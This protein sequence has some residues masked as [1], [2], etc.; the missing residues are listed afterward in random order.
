MFQPED[1]IEKLTRL[2]S[3]SILMLHLNAVVK[4]APKERALLTVEGHAL[5]LAYPTTGNTLL[6][7]RQSV[8]VAPKTAID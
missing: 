4:G 5:K 1:T 7:V 3:N 6:D 8:T 2:Y